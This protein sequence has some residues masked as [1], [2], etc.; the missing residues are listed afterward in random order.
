MDLNFKPRLTGGFLF[1]L[2][3]ESKTEFLPFAS[4]TDFQI[5]VGSYFFKKFLEV[6]N[7]SVIEMGK[8]K[9]ERETFGYISCKNELDIFFGEKTSEILNKFLDDYTNHYFELLKRTTNFTNYLFNRKD[10]QKINRSINKIINI[11]K[12]DETIPGKQNFKIGFY[13]STTKSNL[14]KTRI[15]LLEPFL[16]SVIFYIVTN[17]VKNSYG[18]TTYYKYFK[19]NQKNNNYSELEESNIIVIS[20]NVNDLYF[21]LSSDNL[22]SFSDDDKKIRKYLKDTFD[23]YSKLKTLLYTEE[24]HNFKDFYVCNRIQKQRDPKNEYASEYDFGDFD[25]IIEFDLFDYSEKKILDD[26]ISFTVFD[27]VKKYTNFVII[28]GTGGLGK[29]MMMRHFLINS[30]EEYDTYKII[31]IFIPLKDFESG[32]GTLYDFIFSRFSH[33]NSNNA[34][35]DFSTKLSQG[36]FLLLFDGLDE[37]NSKSIACFEQEMELF[38]DQY[39]SNLF[40]MSSR[41]F[42]DFVS[43]NRFTILQLLP[44]TKSQ[45]I[46]LVTKLDL[47]KDGEIVKQKFVNEIDQ[48][49]FDTHNDFVTNPLLLTIMLITFEQYAEIPSK[50]H[51]FY[52]E[53]YYALAQKHDATKGAYKREFKTGLSADRFSDYFAEFCT[54]SYCDEQVDFSYNQIKNYFQELNELKNDKD[55]AKINFENFLDDIVFGLCLLYYEGNEYHFTHR[56]FQEY[57]CALYFSKQLDKNLESIGDFFESKSSKLYADTTFFMLYDMIPE[58]VKL[59]IFIPYLKKLLNEC[60]S[61]EGYQTFLEKQYPLIEYH[62]GETLGGEVL[63]PKSII[64]NTIKTMVFKEKNTILRENLPDLERTRISAFSRITLATKAGDKESHFERLVEVTSILE[65]EGKVR[66]SIKINGTIHRIDISDI[67]KHR[68]KNIEIID[69]LEKEDFALKKEYNYIKEYLKNNENVD[70][71]NQNSLMKMLRACKN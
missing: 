7:S 5:K 58:K 50:M 35:E 13:D 21:S 30:L 16:L 12:E 19:S 69:A 54:A 15:I 3:V 65:K 57:F 41:P 40:V 44:L 34:R 59:Y 6:F 64:Y 52:R 14:D 49:L 8:K 39:S 36:R 38:C 47:G 4:E 9:F 55:N 11:I 37:I 63:C 51:I 61:K 17:K 66:D 29:S 24:P 43:F 42:S 71:N 2:L 56:S 46:K 28:T 27:V 33:E 32:R 22:K 60:E 26:G 53:A 31:P 1:S 48:K 18:K 45:S 62:I 67:Y 10:V 23:K 25:D 20:L 70:Y 68:E